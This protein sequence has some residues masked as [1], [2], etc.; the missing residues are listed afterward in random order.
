MLLGAQ[1]L[2]AQHVRVVVVPSFTIVPGRW[3]VR[4]RPPLFVVS[5]TRSANESA[6]TQLFIYAFSPTLIA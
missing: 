6:S 4:Q 2:L 5:K 3:L 1:F